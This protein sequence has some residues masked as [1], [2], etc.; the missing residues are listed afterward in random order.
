MHLQTRGITLV[1]L[2]AGFASGASPVVYQVA[3]IAGSDWVGDGGAAIS[4]QMAQ[5]EGLAVAAGGSLYIAD[6]ANHR[7][8]KVTPDGLIVTIAGNGHPGFAGDGGPAAA[9]QLNQPY[10]LA[11][12]ASGNLYVAD[13]GNQRV[14]RIDGNGIITTVAGDGLSGSNGDAGP[15]ISA[16]LLGPRNLAIDPAGNLY[17]SE[18][19]GHRV[20]RVAPD[21]TIRTV[22]GT[23]I[24]GNGGD[25]GPAT[26]A[27][28]AFPAGLALDA[29]GSLYIVDTVNVRIRKVR[30]GIITTVCDQQKFGQPYN[31]LSGIAADSAGN[32]YI[33]DGEFIFRLSPDGKLAPATNQLL[34]GNV[35]ADVALDAAGNLDVS[36]GHIVEQISLAGDSMTPLAGN[37]GFSFSGDGGDALLSVLNGPVGL[38]WLNGALYIADQG[39]DR[40]R[41]VDS[42]GVMATVA[43]GAADMQD[44]VPATQSSLGRPAGL[45][46]DLAGNLF[47][48]DSQDNRVRRL[49]ASVTISTAAG[50]GTSSGYGCEGCLAT[51]TP[52]DSPQGVAADAHG[53]LFIADTHH[54]RVIRVDPGGA[55]HTISGTGTPGNLDDA[56]LSELQGPTGLALDSDGNLYIADS[57]NHRIRMLTPAGTISTVAGSGVSGFSGDGGPAADAEL[58]SPAA[59]AVDSA[60]NLYIADSGNNRIRMVTPD[61]NISTLA[62]TGTDGF[63]GESGPA[64]QIA[65]SNPCGLAFD[66]QGNLLVADTGN[67][68]VRRLSQTVVPPPALV[69]ITVTNAASLQPWPVAP[70]EIIAIFGEGLGPDTAASGVYDSSGMLSTAL[71]DTQVLFDNIPAPL[72]YV[73]STQINAQA[74]YELT[75]RASTQLQVIYQ[76]VLVASQQVSLTGASPALFTANYGTGNAVI[77]N[78][79][80]TI[81]SSQ[82]P[83]ARGSLV[84][85]YATGA[86]QT[87]PAGVTGQGAQAPFSQPLLPV[88]LTIANV[89]ATILWAGSAP[90]FVGLM[91]INARV[92]SGFVPPGDLPVLLSVG[93]YTSPS[94]VTMA[95][96]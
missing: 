39:N 81:N 19:D 69:T 55:I 83:A 68:R 60:G 85:L 35:A 34:A 90:G 16:L 77:V 89:P 11:L 75:G 15:A 63:N 64:L 42:N 86:G 56:A 27:Q 54:N 5:P 38:A 62:G 3:T 76:G 78:E 48:A 84:V 36:M 24:A 17:I 87:D 6:A 2:I 25:G 57:G 37:G 92:P 43:G 29:A 30:A 33:P 73:Q 23:G 45:A 70:G 67:N 72:F 22:A 52:L 93:T 49:D 7:I 96:R 14:R 32:L 82:N 12:D 44:G 4:A 28:L 18:F 59:V 80:G 46:S 50:N 20:R 9:A 51:L 13:Y 1:L 61:G 74:P 10:G 65:L 47:L 94:G 91:Q 88:S 53:N 95:V 8:R 41:A 58:N 79:D 31:Q 66:G 40:I 71:A 21:G 26:A